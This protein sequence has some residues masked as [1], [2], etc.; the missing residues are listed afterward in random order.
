[1]KRIMLAILMLSVTAVRFTYAN[2]CPESQ[3]SDYYLGGLDTSVETARSGDGW[4]HGGV[5]TAAYWIGRTFENGAS[6][7]EGELRLSGDMAI[8]LHI[9]KIVALDFGFG[10][11]G[12]VWGEN[13][14]GSPPECDPTGQR[15]ISIDPIVYGGCKLSVGFNKFSLALCWR[16]GLGYAV[17][18][19]EDHYV[20]YPSVLIGFSNP[21]R[22]TL[23]VGNQGVAITHHRGLVHLGVFLLPLFCGAYYGGPSP[24]ICL[25][26]YQ[27]PKYRSDRFNYAVGVKAGFGRY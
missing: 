20:N 24:S 13:S 5:Q 10:L 12:I 9:G 16:T 11:G 19:Y 27:P 18:V 25:S 15:T 22:W 3:C 6:G 1:M 21:E 26:S 4:L 23:G 7:G 14:L 17:N 8:A 2:P